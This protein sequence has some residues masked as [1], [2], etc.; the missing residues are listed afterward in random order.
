MSAG[1]CSAVSLLR[2][3]WPCC[4]ISLWKCGRYAFINVRAHAGHAVREQ[5]CTVYQCAGSQFPMTAGLLG[6]LCYNSASPGNTDIKYADQQ[7]A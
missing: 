3:S 5:G 2:L 1:T 6:R 7:R 4:S